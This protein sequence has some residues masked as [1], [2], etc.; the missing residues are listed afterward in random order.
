M[1]ACDDQCK[2]LTWH[3]KTRSCHINYPLALIMKFHLFSNI[4]DMADAHFNLENL[5]KT[6]KNAQKGTNYF[7][8][9]SP[10]GKDE[11]ERFANCFTGRQDLSSH[12]GSLPNPSTHPDSKDWQ[13]MSRAFR[14]AL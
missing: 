11:L 7:I 6:V 14:V 10:R 12:Y 3:S 13:I 5:A 2:L 9:V 1:N 4:L 8:C